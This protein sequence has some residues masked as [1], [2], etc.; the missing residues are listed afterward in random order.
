MPDNKKKYWLALK[1]IPRLATAKKL[2]LVQQ[3]GLEQ[4]FRQSLNTLVSIGLSPNQV[5]AILNPDW[6]KISNILTSSEK[7]NAKVICFDSPSYPKK[8]TQIYDPP[9]VL[10]LKGNGVLL[11]KDQLAI[12]GSRNAS[13]AGRE[14]A[15]QMAGELVRKGLVITSGLAFGIDSFAHRGALD[16]QGET[17]AVMA[18]G[19]DIIYPRRNR[20]L[21]KDIIS[22]GGALVTEFLPGTS[23][24]KGHFPR[25]NRIISGM[26]HGV[27]VVE[28]AIKSGSLIT[29]RLA[30]E[31]NRE[32]FAIPGTINNEQSK[33]CHHLIKMGAKLVDSTVD[34]IEELTAFSPTDFDTKTVE[35]NKKN[36]QQDLFLD[37][38]LAN[39]GYETTPVDLVVSRSKL[40]IDAVLT[41]LTMLEL[42]G[43]VSAVPGGYLR[44]NGG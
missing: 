4:V 25:R 37:P 35:K 17:V 12:I 14:N 24:N 38:L 26:S 21:A 29:A 39:V 10:F 8:L 15:H 7:H 2:T 20:Q 42:R 28:A 41:R 18:T 43:L 16:Y 27:L 11:Q 30:L 5:D 23:P 6:L 44:L 9:L 33:G 40:P 3:F 34:I 36:A 31:Q 32:V 19:I 13:V 22:N 1:L